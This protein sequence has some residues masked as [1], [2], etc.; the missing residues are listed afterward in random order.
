MTLCRPARIRMV[1]AMMLDDEVQMLR[2]VS[3]FGKADPC[4][5]KLMAF[6]SDRV[7]YN[8]GEVLFSQG[9]QADA[10][11]VILRGEAEL[12]VGSASVDIKIGTVGPQS[13]VGEMCLLRDAPRAATVRASGE[14]EALRINR[15]CFF[16]VIADNPR[17]GIEVSRALAETLRD[18]AIQLQAPMAKA[19][20]PSH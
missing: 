15:D 17:I 3:Y 1:D 20:E 14:V 16:R 7:C 10:A 9:D 6:S 12:W 19:T 11:Y 8:P 18:Q 13:I 2:N 5:L 4:K